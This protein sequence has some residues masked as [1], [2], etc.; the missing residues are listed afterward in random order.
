MAWPWGLWGQPCDATRAHLAPVAW[1]V[2]VTAMNVWF[3]RPVARW[4]GLRV[5]A[6]HWL[7]LGLTQPMQV[8]MLLLAKMGLLNFVG[9]PSHPTWKGR[10]CAS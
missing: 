9:I 3:A 4:F 8:P 6:G 2:G 10:T 1:W 7:V 5:N